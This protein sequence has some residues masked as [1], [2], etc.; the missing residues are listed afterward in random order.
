M[1][2]LSKNKSQNTQQLDLFADMRNENKQNQS[3]EASERNSTENVPILLDERKV[4]KKSSTTKI[5]N[6][7]K[8]NES[9]HSVEVS[10]SH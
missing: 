4:L 7:N 8:E 3:L 5:F 9:E 1:T 10:A 2:S 6:L